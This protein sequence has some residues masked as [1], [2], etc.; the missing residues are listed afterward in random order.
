MALLV[1]MV[2]FAISYSAVEKVLKQPMCLASV[3]PGK[4]LRR[5]KVNLATGIHLE[6]ERGQDRNP[7]LFMQY[8]SLMKTIYRL[9]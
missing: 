8:S 6:E 5:R 3:R 9:G 4:Y 1:Y 7:A 2:F